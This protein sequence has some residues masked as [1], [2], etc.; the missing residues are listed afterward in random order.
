M[1][2]AHEYELNAEN[3]ATAALGS[4]DRDEGLEFLRQSAVWRNKA[5][6]LLLSSRADL[7]DVCPFSDEQLTYS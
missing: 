5:L 2:N 1:L 6:H 4:R 7:L 3:C